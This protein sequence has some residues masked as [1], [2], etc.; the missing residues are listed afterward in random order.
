[1]KIYLASEADSRQQASLTKVGY[2]HRLLSYF[3]LRKKKPDVLRNI[4]EPGLVANQK[5]RKPR[6]KK[7]VDDK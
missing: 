4:V 2:K 6:D 3:Y 7:N 1:M 5:P